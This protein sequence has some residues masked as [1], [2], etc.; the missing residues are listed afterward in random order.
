M[1]ECRYFFYIEHS[2]KVATKRHFNYDHFHMKTKICLLTLKRLL[3]VCKRFAHI[4]VTI[5]KCEC[6]ERFARIFRQSITR[7]TGTSHNRINHKINDADELA[8]VNT[9]I[10][11]RVGKHRL[12]A[13]A[14]EMRDAPE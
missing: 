13:C 8:I 5:F 14:C 2:P 11:H 12:Q 10:G 3:T 6:A 4:C 9:S 1:C 7:C